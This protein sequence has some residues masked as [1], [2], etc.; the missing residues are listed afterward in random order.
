MLCLC[1]LFGLT[2]HKRALELSGYVFVWSVFLHHVG[3]KVE[4]LLTHVTNI[5]LHLQAVMNISL[6]RHHL[7]FF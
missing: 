4:W 5:R 7:Q 2:V 3:Y 1:H 6:S